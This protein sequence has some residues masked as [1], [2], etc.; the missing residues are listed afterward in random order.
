[1]K[2]IRSRWDEKITL[3][4]LFRERF[5]SNIISGLEGIKTKWKE[6]GGRPGHL[7]NISFVDEQGIELEDRGQKYRSVSQEVVDGLLR[8]YFK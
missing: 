4:I 2:L 1:M 5:Q 8:Q 7:M 3:T 6:K